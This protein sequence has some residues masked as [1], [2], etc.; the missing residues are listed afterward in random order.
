MTDSSQDYPAE[1]GEIMLQVKILPDAA[2]VE[3]QKYKS[4]QSMVYVNTNFGVNPR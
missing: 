4:V 2:A 1:N 3:C